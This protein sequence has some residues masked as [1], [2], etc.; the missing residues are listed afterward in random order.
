MVIRLHIYRGGQN[1]LPSLLRASGLATGLTDV[2]N[3]F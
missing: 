2:N 3:G 1:N